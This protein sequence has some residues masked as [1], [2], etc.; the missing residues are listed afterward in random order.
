MSDLRKRPTPELRKRRLRPFL[1]REKDLSNF[2]WALEKR[3]YG[4]LCVL[5]P[6]CPFWWL[7]DKR[8]PEG[9]T[10][11]KREK[12]AERTGSSV[13]S[14]PWSDSGCSAPEVESQKS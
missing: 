2:E 11:K 6:L 10:D 8:E 9:K 5:L 13:G 4:L 14:R 12:I 7:I 1:P 3:A